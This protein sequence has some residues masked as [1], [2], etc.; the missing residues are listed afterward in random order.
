MEDVI[1]KMALAVLINRLGGSVEITHAE[2]EALEMSGTIQ[3]ENDVATG[4]LRLAVVTERP[5][6]SS[7]Q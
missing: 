3:V 1:T 2:L 6:G 4:V 5:A 7:L